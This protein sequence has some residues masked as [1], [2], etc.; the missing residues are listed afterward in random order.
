MSRIT[1]RGKKK[2]YHRKKRKKRQT[3]SQQLKKSRDMQSFGQKKNKIHRQR[4]NA[5]IKTVPN[6]IGANYKIN[7]NSESEFSY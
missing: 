4:C 3:P 7:L 6:T 1:A 2:K 5:T